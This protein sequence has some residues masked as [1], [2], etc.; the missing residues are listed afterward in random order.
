MASSQ[1]QLPLKEDEKAYKRKL[2]ESEQKIKEEKQKC[3]KK[4]KQLK[5]KKPK[6]EKM[7]TKKEPNEHIIEGKVSS[8]KPVPEKY[9]HLVDEG[10][11]IYEVPGDGTCAPSCAA[12]FYFKMRNLDIN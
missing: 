1:W 7:K 6:S 10:D 2:N 11:L 9:A 5:R 3:A 4:L 8:L 12:A